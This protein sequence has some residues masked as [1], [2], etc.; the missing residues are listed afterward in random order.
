[1]LK[2]VWFTFWRYLTLNVL[3]IHASKN[4]FKTPCYQPSTIPNT[5]TQMTFTMLFHH[6]Y[7]VLEIKELHGVVWLTQFVHFPG[8]LFL[9]FTASELLV[10]PQKKWMI[11]SVQLVF[12]NCIHILWLDILNLLFKDDFKK[13]FPIFKKNFVWWFCHQDKLVLWKIFIS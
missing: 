9:Y 2:L 11:K 12:Q 5:L 8:L 4:L 6:F 1:M 3:Q 10:K 7:K 13:K